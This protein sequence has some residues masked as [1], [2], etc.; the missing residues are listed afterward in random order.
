MVLYC[1][2]EKTSLAIT[3]IGRVTRVSARELCNT[4]DG[5]TSMFMYEESVSL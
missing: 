2:L 1:S 5:E 4:F 3:I